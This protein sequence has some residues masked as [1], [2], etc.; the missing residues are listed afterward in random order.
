MKR[1]IIYLSDGELHELLR[2][3]RRLFIIGLVA[4]LVGGIGL[5]WIVLCL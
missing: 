5:A 3:P 2:F 4:G 1:H